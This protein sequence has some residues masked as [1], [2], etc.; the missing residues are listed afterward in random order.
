M[1]GKG[2]FTYDLHTGMIF[3]GDYVLGSCQNLPESRNTF[4]NKM[5]Y[6]LNG[7]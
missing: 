3:T 2:P 5:T 4:R 6:Y 1:Q 7:I